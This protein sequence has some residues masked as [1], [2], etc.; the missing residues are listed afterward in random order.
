M[1]YDISKA[2]APKMPNL[3]N[4]LDCIKLIASQ[5]SPDMREAIIPAI[6]PALSAYVSGAEFQYADLTWK[7]LCGSMAHLIA[8]SGMGKGQLTSCI[9]AIM[10]KFR[11]HD[12]EELQKL[13]SWQKA[14]K[15]K[16][17]NKEKPARPEVAFFFPPSDATNP[18]FLQNAMACEAYGGHTQF[19]NMT[20][21][22]QA[23]RLCGGHKQVS[24]TIRN[25]YDKQRAGAL[26]ATADGITGN[27]TLRVNLT[28]SSTPIAARRFYKNEL[29]VGTFGRIPFSYKARENRS[30][31]IPR[32]GRFDE[33]FLAKLDEYIIRLED[34]KGRFIIPQLNKLADKLA[35]D[36]ASIADLADNDE[37]WDMG[38]RA[39]VSAWKNGCILFIL[40]GQ[41]WTRAMGEFVEWLVYHDIWSKM[42]VFGDMLKDGDTSTSEIGKTGPRNMLEDLGDTFNE[43]ELEALR[44]NAGKPKEGTKRQ[45][46]VWVSRHFIEYSAQTGL[47]SKT[48]LYLNRKR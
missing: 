48:K 37:V 28:F 36:V 44:A 46:A 5:I 26:R 42:Q 21:I 27:P 34:C 6:F 23:D 43:S 45:L 17:A 8:E 16:G 24:Q 20:E 41:C 38:K 2:T 12:E 32:V 40:N 33:D 10:R 4:G 39:I 29:H 31:K 9:E 14:V 1:K 18:A 30:G 35:D 11:K 47:Y 7:E 13:V 3:A 15:T 19:F 25:I 22:E